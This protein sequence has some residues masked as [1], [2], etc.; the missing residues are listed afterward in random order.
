MSKTEK[1]LLESLAE[2]V[3]QL[4]ENKRDFLMGYA[5]GVNAMARTEEPE[6][7]EK[8]DWKG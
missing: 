3:K 4:P 2:A 1:M 8:E 7:K 6:E 5:E